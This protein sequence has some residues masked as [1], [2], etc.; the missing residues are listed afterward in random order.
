MSHSPQ[1]I[2]RQTYLKRML[3]PF[4][5]RAESALWYAH[6]AF[7]VR[8][9]L[10]LPLQQPS[11]EFGCMEGISTFIMLG[12]EF[13]LGFDVYSEVSW[14]KDSIKW[15]SLEE[16]D[17]Y[18]THKKDAHQELDIV[19]QPDEQFE[20][21]T[22]WKEAHLKKANRLG[23]YKNITSQDDP[24]MPL[25]TIEDNHFKTIWAPNLY[26][27]DHLPKIMQ[28]L[29]RILQP[30]GQLVTVLPDSSALDHMLYRFKDQ[31]DAEWINNLDRGR[32]SNIARQA[33]NLEEWSQF[34]KNQNWKIDQHEHFLPKLVFQVNDIGLRPMFPVFM[35]IYET[36][37]TQSPEQWLSIKQHWIDTAFH[38]LA[39]MCD[40]EWMQKLQ[41]DHVWHIFRLKPVNK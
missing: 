13:G 18:N 24:I 30:E 25:T 2:T 27:M 39:P 38:F 28:E 29:H 12:G 4:W 3:C 14:S 22:C 15:V 19:R 9:Y 8:Q 37:R 5:L 17:Y 34:F 31:A 26:W 33:R 35:N 16:S 7:L 6:E 11:L 36:L 20:L 32:Y 40:V 1:I 21:G 10:G 23:S 41:Q